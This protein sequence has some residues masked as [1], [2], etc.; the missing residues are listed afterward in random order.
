MTDGA[1]ERRREEDRELAATLARLDERWKVVSDRLDQIDARLV[2]A[3]GLRVQVAA[4]DARV[5]ISYAL[6]T[7][8]VGGLIGLAFRVLGA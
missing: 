2:A 6:L 7:L 3:N 4:L 8:I 5:K 1:T